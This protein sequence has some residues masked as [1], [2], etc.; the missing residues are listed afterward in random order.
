MMLWTDKYAPKSPREITGQKKPLEE[1]QAFLRDWRPGRAL[2]LYGPPGTG[3]SL[4]VETL[5]VERDL[6]LLRMNASDRRTAGEVESVTGEASRQRPLFRRGRFIL[7]DEMDGIAGGDRGA[8]GAIANLIKTSMF[9]VFLIA[10]DPWKPKLLPLRSHCRFVKF[11]RLNPL[12]IAKRLGEICREEGI[13]AEP[14]ALKSL[15]RWSRGDMRSAILDL[16]NI[17]QGRKDIKAGDLEA[18]GFR[19]RESSVFESLPVVFH[20][21][22]LSAS[23]KAIQETER[24]PDDIFWWIEHNMPRELKTPKELARGLEILAK[25]DMFRQ[26]VRKHQNW[27]FKA[28]MVDL[29]SGSSLHKE[30]HTG[31]VQYQPPGKLLMMG[32]TRARRAAMLEMCRKIGRKTHCSPYRARRD[33]LPYLK[34]ILKK[35]RGMARA[36]DL[37]Q[38]ELELIGERQPQLKKS[39]M[40]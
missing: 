18:L 39:K 40:N 13:H 23:R 3:K 35:Q 14:D 8:V 22:S 25:A 10:N 27:R 33:I 28:Y 19:E 16:Q 12:S 17:C 31:W 37:T 38:E 1:S 7:L 21:R 32:R 15:A 26:R 29:L 2:F 30:S 24:D 34:I 6:L 5:A 11:S 4:L 36:L 9:P 20:S